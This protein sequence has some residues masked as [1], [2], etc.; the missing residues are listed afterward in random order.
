M[1]T[2]WGAGLS[3]FHLQCLAWC[4]TRPFNICGMNEWINETI[5]WGRRG[6]GGF[7]HS[8][9]RHSSAL[10]WEDRSGRPDS[11]DISS[12]ISGCV[13]GSRVTESIPF[14]LVTFTLCRGYRWH[15]KSWKW[16]LW[17]TG[18]LWENVTHRNHLCLPT[19]WQLNCGLN[20]GVSPSRSWQ[21]CG[22]LEDT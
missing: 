15:P 16:V 11:I 22:K 10:E 8:L 18:N 20:R 4:L 3:P 1:E 14:K 17:V 2:I 6:R 21:P 9:A 7:L 5:E 12:P 13:L 19:S